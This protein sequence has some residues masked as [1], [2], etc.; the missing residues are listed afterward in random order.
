MGR[1]AT[2]TSRNSWIAIC[3]SC[4]DWKRQCPIPLERPISFWKRFNSWEDFFSGTLWWLGGFFDSIEWLNQRNLLQ[5]QSDALTKYVQKDIISFEKKCVKSA[6][7]RFQNTSYLPEEAQQLL[8]RNS[9]RHITSVEIP[10]GR[11]PAPVG[12]SLAL[13]KDPYRL[14]VA[15]PWQKIPNF[16]PWIRKIFQSWEASRQYDLLLPHHFR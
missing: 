14:V 8:F 4:G 6:V 10:I 12:C 13:A 2:S 9:V 1:P 3:A 7:P 5:E 15:L 11:F 16:G